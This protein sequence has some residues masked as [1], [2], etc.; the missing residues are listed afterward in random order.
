MIDFETIIIGAGPY[1]LSSASYLKAAG[2]RVGVFGEPMEFWQ[3]QVPVGTF[4]ASDWATAHIAHPKRGLSLDAF[5]TSIGTRIANPIPLE[6]FVEYGLW[7]QNRSIPDLDRRKVNCV[8]RNGRGFE[9]T[10]VD[11][12]TVTSR[13]V[14]IATG[15]GHFAWRPKQFDALPPT[16]ASH[17]S[18]HRDLSRFCGQRVLVI[19]GGQSALEAARLLH[20]SECEVEVI[21]RGKTLN[22][23]GLNRWLHHLGFISR[24]LYS[25]ADVGPAGISRIIA[26]PNLF[27]KLPSHL[28]DRFSYRATRPAGSSW[29]RPRLAQVPITLGREI[30][31][32]SAVGSRVQARL[33]DGTVRLA[34]HMLLATGYRID[35]SQYEFLTQDIHKRLQ[36]A[37]GYPVLGRGL[38][39]SVPGLHFLGKPAAWSFGPLLNFISGTEFASKELVRCISSA[40]RKEAR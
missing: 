34:D 3:N 18:E 31:S 28:Q 20:E 11:G 29:M 37:R 25:S 13:R 16:H 24:C 17:S 2:V 39:S 9:V 15:I 22:W 36:T 6:R 23:V 12:Q 19:G 32:A 8:D 33:G 1:G 21:A 7:Y 4:L 5:Q 26:M 14:A 35:T 10:L 27:R 30:A 38:E 40:R